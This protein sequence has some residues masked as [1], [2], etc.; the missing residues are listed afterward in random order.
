MSNELLRIKLKTETAFPLNLIKDMQF[1]FLIMSTPTSV[2]VMSN[3]V[4]PACRQA[5]ISGFTNSGGHL[6]IVTV[7]TSIVLRFLIPC[8]IQKNVRKKIPVYLFFFELLLKIIFSDNRF[9]YLT[10]IKTTPV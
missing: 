3:K 9:L 1:L 6:L 8:T 10:D 7:I 5:G 2:F 4:R